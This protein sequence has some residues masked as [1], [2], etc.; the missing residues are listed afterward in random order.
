[1]AKSSKKKEEEISKTKPWALGFNGH[2]RI[3]DCVPCTGMRVAA[4]KKYYSESTKPP[5]MPDKERTV[6][7]R[8]HWRK[9]PNHLTRFPRFKKAL[10]KTFL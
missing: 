8:A 7:V 4:F 5:L 10:I 3:C 6:F 1:M 9:Q 2:A